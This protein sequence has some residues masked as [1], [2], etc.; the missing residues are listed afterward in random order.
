MSHF[1]KGLS[2][3]KFN[4]KYPVGSSFKYFPI[5][6]VPDSVEVVTRTEAWALGHG[7]V[8]VSVNGRAGGLHIEHMKPVVMNKH[9][10]ELSKPVAWTDAEEL[11]EMNSGSYANIFNGNEINTADGQWM[12]LYSQ[13]YVNALLAKME[14]AEKDSK[15]LEQSLNVANAATQT[16]KQRA[17]ASGARLL[18][19][20]E[21]AAD[22]IGEAASFMSAAEVIPVSIVIEL[23][24]AAGYPVK[25][26]SNDY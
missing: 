13:E 3:D 8:V 14:A 1:L 25:V 11:A 17:E 2:A 21:L 5:M 4:Q 6:G 20:V 10:D 12:A 7:A 26:A 16:W 15:E 18:V 22:E 19:P 24:K 9:I 23:I